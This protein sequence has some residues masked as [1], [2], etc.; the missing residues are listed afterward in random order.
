[1]KR[2][3]VNHFRYC[4]Y[5]SPAFDITKIGDMVHISSSDYRLIRD[6]L[7]EAASKEQKEATVRMH[8]IDFV[9]DITDHEFLFE[10]VLFSAKARLRGA[11]KDGEEVETDFLEYKIAVI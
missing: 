9:F 5:K 11:F 7:R 2:K 10:G 8:D 6:I 3:N 4:R 1:M